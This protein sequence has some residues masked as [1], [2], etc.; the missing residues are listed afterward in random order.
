MPLPSALYL[1]NAALL[2]ACSGD[3]NDQQEE[4]LWNLF[5]NGASN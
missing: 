2:W 1:R 4:K 5:G 3:N